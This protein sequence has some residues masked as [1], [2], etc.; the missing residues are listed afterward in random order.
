VRSHVVNPV[1]RQV[2]ETLKKHLRLPRTD[3]PT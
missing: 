3:V 2:F 1:T